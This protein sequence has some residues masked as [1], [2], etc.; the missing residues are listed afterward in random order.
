MVWEDPGG[1]GGGPKMAFAPGRKGL[2]KFCE[3][4]KVWLDKSFRQ[5]ARR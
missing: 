5:P 2:R 3:N 1:G 4:S